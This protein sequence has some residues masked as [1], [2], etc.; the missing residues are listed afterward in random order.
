MILY[1]IKAHSQMTDENI[2]FTSSNSN[3]MDNLELQKAIFDFLFIDDDTT[4]KHYRTYI[5]SNNVSILKDD[6]LP[7]KEHIQMKIFK[8]FSIRF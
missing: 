6:D 5:L 2:Y 4:A 8:T 1:T 7:L 3:F